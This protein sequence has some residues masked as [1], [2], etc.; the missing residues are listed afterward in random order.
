MTTLKEPHHQDFSSPSDNTHILDA[1]EAAS[2]R[3]DV[4]N[5]M[6]THG[7]DNVALLWKDINPV[8]RAALMLVRNFDQSKIIHG[9]DDQSAAAKSRSDHPNA[10]GCADID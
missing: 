8:Q 4:R 9:L 1:L 7:Y 6:Q 3:D 10:N 5:L 2:T